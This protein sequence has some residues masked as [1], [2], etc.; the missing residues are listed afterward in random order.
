MKN[1]KITLAYNGTNY[2]GWQIQPNGITVQ[3]VIEKSL[4][5]L[6][7]GQI[8]VIGQGRT[9]TG[10]HAIGQVASFKLPAIALKN[11]KISQI[12]DALNSVLPQDIAVTNVESVSLDFHPRF[13]AKDRI[14]RYIVYN[15]G[16]KQVLG[17]SFFYSYQ[18][19]LDLSKMRKGAKYLVGEHDFSSFQCKKTDN[20]NP[21]RTIKKLTIARRDFVA[22]NFL[23]LK[24]KAVVFEVTANA[25]L[26]NMVRII[27]GTLLDIGRCRIEPQN[28]KKILAGRDRNLAG[29]TVPACGLCLIAV[30]Y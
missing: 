30:H 4:E 16:N 10:V 9:D 12:K 23:K 27:V 6:F 17:Q 1:I 25:F 19:K 13:D 15:D 24:N 20:E 11:M 26:Y 2:H 14:Y 28:I 21:V 29:E 18:Y 3:S 22:S 7:K 5:R 8:K